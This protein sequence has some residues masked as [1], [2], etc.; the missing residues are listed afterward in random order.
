M[1]AFSPVTA[2]VMHGQRPEKPLHAE[3]LGFSDTIWE[4]VKSCWNESSSTRPSAEKL[5]EDLSAAAALPWVPPSVYPIEVNTENTGAD[6]S[7]S[8]G[9]SLTW[10]G[11][12]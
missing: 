9:A 5:F 12:R 6:A 4:L 7:G 2:V 8:S 11:T 1:R 10:P 3:S